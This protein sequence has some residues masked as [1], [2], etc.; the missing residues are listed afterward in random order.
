MNE[1]QSIKDIDPAGIVGAL[2]DLSTVQAVARDGEFA[3]CPFRVGWGGTWRASAGRGI[4]PLDE[5]SRE[6]ITLDSD[7]GELTLRRPLATHSDT[8]GDVTGV[9]T[10]VELRTRVLDPKTPLVF[11]SLVK[12][13]EN[14]WTRLFF[15]CS[16]RDVRAGGGARAYLPIRTAAMVVD[17]FFLKEGPFV[18]VETPIEGDDAGTLDEARQ[19]LGATRQLLTYMTGTPL[20]ADGCDALF[21]RDTNELVAAHWYQGRKREP[22]IYHPIPC[23][24]SEWT[25]SQRALGRQGTNPSRGALNPDVIAKCLQ[26][27]L[28]NP[29]LV[30]PT[31]YLIRFPEAPV[32]MRGAFLAVALESLTDHLQKT[33]VL[34]SVALLPEEIWNPLRDRLLDVLKPVWDSLQ[35][36]QRSALR[37]RINGLN[38]ATNSQKL[39]LPFDKLGVSLS[40]EERQAIDR[41]NK[42][43]H[44]GRLIDPDRAAEDRDAWRAAYVVE[45]RMY[46]VINKLFLKYLGYEGPIIDWGNTSMESGEQAYAT[47]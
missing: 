5:I 44:Q 10:S 23:S 11:R 12:T 29:A 41:R 20:D 40:S 27:F 24:W 15:P 35:E 39:N 18:V 47:L 26:V 32:E 9:A 25:S 2:P 38:A 30:T 42:L 14:L 21:L 45:M 28:D 34:D 1:A 46:T 4:V 16:F 43:L 22:H 13:D 6:T 36:E 33:G 3:G 17:V 7:V 31:E 8:D 37:N 19:L